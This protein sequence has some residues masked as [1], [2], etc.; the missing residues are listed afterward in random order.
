M[1]MFEQEHLVLRQRQLALRLRSAEL[2]VTLATELG[3]VEPL[4]GWVDRARAAWNGW[5]QAAPLWRVL[6]AAGSVAAMLGL[7]RQ[8]SRLRRLLVLG[9]RA[10]GLWALWRGWR[11]ARS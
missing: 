4:L 7:L 6:A 3:R 5:Q 9:R 2:R 11:A 10:A 1:S 8:P